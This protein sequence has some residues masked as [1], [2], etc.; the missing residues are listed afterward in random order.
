MR[1]V[2]AIAIICLTA[3]VMSVAQSDKTIVYGEHDGLSHRHVTQ[4]LQDKYGFIWLST[5]NGLDRFD[6]REFVTFKSRPGDGV[7]MPSDRMR[8]IAIDDH[9]DNIINCRVDD[10]W[11]RFS[12]LTG[13]FTPVSTTEQKAIAA[14]PGHGCGKAVKEIVCGGSYSPTAR[15][16]CGQFWPTVSVSHHPIMFQPRSRDGAKML[17]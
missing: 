11:F 13:K 2:M 9:N 12:L 3:A 1:R 7:A 14:H 4:I 16:C 17:R 5:W 15:A 6:G 10:S 8:K